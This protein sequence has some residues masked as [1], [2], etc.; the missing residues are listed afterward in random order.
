MFRLLALLQLTRFALAFTAIADAWA[1]LLLRAPTTVPPPMWVLIIQMIVTGVVS[2][3]L[4]GFGMTLN[5]LL[6]ARRDRVFAPRRPIPS[7]RIR[8]RSA[9]IIALLLLM[10]S[11]FASAALTPI[12]VALTENPRWKDFVPWSF[13]FS[14]ATA[15]LIVFY[16]ATSKYLGGLGLVTLGAIR[17]LHC[18]I[19]NPRTGLI[20]LCMFLLTH[21]I[22]ISTIAYKLENKRPRLRTWDYVIIALGLLLGNLMAVIYMLWRGVIDPSLLGMVAAPAIAMLVYAIWAVQI[23]RNPKHAPR[24]KGERLMLLGLFWLFVYDASM[25]LGNGQ[26]LAGIAITL[27]LLCAIVSFFGLR[28]I[29]RTMG[30]PKL[31]YRTEREEKVTTAR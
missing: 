19:G 7:G 9:I 25:L 29:S 4:Y 21:V 16:D 26:Y 1:I 14:F 27:L 5:D 20:V 30:Q 11:L 10:L 28:W 2:F 17:A 31:G 8:I 3:G 13:I 6:D 22:V 18:L 24:Q 12:H 23:L 15:M